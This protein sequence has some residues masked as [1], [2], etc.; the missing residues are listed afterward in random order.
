MKGSSLP[1]YSNGGEFNLQGALDIG[2]QLGNIIG[3]V[4]AADGDLNPYAAAGAG[5]LKGV[6]MGA[7]L[8]NMIVPGI[9]GAIGAG[10]GALIGGAA[11]LIGERRQQAE[12]DR[13]AEEKRRADEMR[14]AQLQAANMQASKAILATYPTSGVADAGF[15]MAYGGTIKKFEDGGVVQPKGD[16][17]EYKKVG[18]KYLTRRR[19]NSNWINAQGTALDAI[20]T[21]IY[22]ESAEPAPQSPVKQKEAPLQ[23]MDYPEDT[24]GLPTMY[25]NPNQVPA[26]PS[27]MYNP[28]PMGGGFSNEIPGNTSQDFRVPAA[29]T[30]APITAE[31][32]APMFAEKPMASSVADKYSDKEVKEMQRLLKEPVRK[33]PKKV[34]S[35]KPK[36]EPKTVEE[37]E[38]SLTKND[39]KDPIVLDDP[40]SID[41]NFAKDFYKKNGVNKDYI[42]V[43]DKPTG[44]MY[45][46]TLDTGEY[47]YLD[48]VGLGKNVGDRDTSKGRSSGKGTNQT[49]SGWVKINREA[50]FTQ[51]NKNYGDEFNGF[52]AYVNGSWKEVP[53]G[54]HGTMAEDCGRVSG[55]CT[56]MN[57][58]L[59]DS[60][61]SMLD[62][63]TLLYYTS[64]NSQGIPMQ[65]MGGPT[66]P[67]PF[68]MSLLAGNSLPSAGSLSPQSTIGNSSVPVTYE[69]IISGA[70]TGAN[71]V[72]SQE[73]R[74]QAVQDAKDFKTNVID[75]AV[76]HPLDATQIALGTTAIA[77]GNTPNPVAQVVGAGADVLNGGISFGRS[78]YYA[79]Q[80]KPGKA[81][82]YA[83]FGAVDMAAGVPGVAGDMASIA[84]MKQLYNLGKGTSEVA[85][86]AE[87]AAHAGH[88]SHS[89]HH[90]AHELSPLITG[91]KTQNAA[92]DIVQGPGM[93]SKEVQPLG[94][95]NR[96]ISMLTP[97]DTAW[98]KELSYMPSRM[99]M[100]GKIPTQSAEYLAEGGEVIQHA[101][102]DV[103]DTDQNGDIKQL[104]SNTSKFEGDSHNDPSQ[105][106][107]ASND[108]QA[109][110]FSNRLYVKKDMLKKLKSL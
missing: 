53:T 33:V 36:P 109:R 64:D 75:Y 13:A 10:A 57:E 98:V 43:V 99:A 108:N 20:R 85:H 62:K 100:G 51:R 90:A 18:D 52:A 101:P 2:S 104:N 71:Q 102:N 4:D 15:M 55:G 42:F 29:A 14:K 72:F 47:K 89:I 31:T 44:A 39:D 12:L 61:R 9:G 96:E 6:G 54:I 87:A 82:M 68:D 94:A 7:K 91:Y 38:V 97:P 16:P 37:V 3:G 58:E 67:P 110:V 49:Q 32:P 45:Q 78:A 86:A 80:G 92:Q 69:D 63:N 21:K 26:Q 56:R 79:N 41:L 106:I 27:P 28:V 23:M 25:P 95:F 17:Y 81:A 70:V 19:G 65:A 30:P 60:T 8:G 77:A 24:G 66:D 5:A 34:A 46:V 74:A 48:Q 84:K 73:N 76:E 59:E 50:E 103:P 40:G 93:Y 35:A 11:G 107:G 22:G 83:G 1:R 105:G 88:A